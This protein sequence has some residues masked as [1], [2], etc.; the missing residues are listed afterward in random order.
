[1]R[2]RLGLLTGLG[3]GY[4]LG[5]AAGRE[6][7][8]QMRDAGQRLMGS[9]RAQDLRSKVGSV[10]GKAGGVIGEKAN[11]GADRLTEAVSSDTESGSSSTGSPGSGAAS[12]AGSAGA[13]IEDHT[14]PPPNLPEGTLP[15]E[16]PPYSS[17]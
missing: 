6:R 1:M 15:G 2:M 5:T 17:R 16:E 14:G 11:E 10:T 8:E 7:Y 13:G 12:G 9:E 3:V 4:V